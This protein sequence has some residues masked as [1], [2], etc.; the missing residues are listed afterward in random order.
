MQHRTA[1]I[2]NRST[3]SSSILLLIRYLGEFVVLLPPLL[4]MLSLVGPGGSLNHPIAGFIPLYIQLYIYPLIRFTR[5]RRRRNSSIFNLNWLTLA[6]CVG[7]NTEPQTHTHGSNSHTLSI[8]LQSSIVR[9]YLIS[10]LAQTEKSFVHRYWSVRGA[11]ITGIR[12]TDAWDRRAT[13]S[14]IPRSGGGRRPP[15]HQQVVVQKKMADDHRGICEKKPSSSLGTHI[16]HPQGQYH[17]REGYY[18]ATRRTTGSRVTE[19]F[20]PE[21]VIPR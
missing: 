3:P 18:P 10:R 20:A 13:E 14:L 5:R 21:R 4:L 11:A 7:S 19:K 17:P 16:L 12:C 1:I 9:Y 2:Q 15:T 6:L 8:Q